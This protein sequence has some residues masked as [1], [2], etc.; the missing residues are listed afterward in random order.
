MSDTTISKDAIVIERTFDASVDLIWQMWTQPE[1]L[2]QWYGP[3][4]FS[5]SIVEMDVRVGGK[6]LF[7]MERQMPDGSMKFW[8]VGEY[9]EVVPNKRLAYTDSMADE[10]GNVASPS[11]YGGNDDEYPLTTLVTVLL[12]D[13]HGRTKM[14]MTHAGVPA[15]EG[16]ASVGW[17]QA[18]VKMADHLETILG[19]KS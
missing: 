1:H 16:G 6:H 19:G 10:H 3:K 2:K 14:V 13:L 5:V 18:F 9:T 8:T 12:E 15:D 4:G 7:C 11:A 17:E